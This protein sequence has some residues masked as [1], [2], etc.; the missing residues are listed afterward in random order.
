[1]GIYGVNRFYLAGSLL[2]VLWTIL[3]SVHL[4]LNHHFLLP[5][6]EQRRA[7]M[8]RYFPTKKITGYLVSCI[9]RIRGNRELLIITGLAVVMRFAAPQGI[10]SGG[11]DVIDTWVSAKRILFGLDYHLIH[12]TVRFGTIIPVYLTQL[13]FGTS[14]VVYYIAPAVFQIMTTVVLFKI[15]EMMM[16]RRFAAVICALFLVFPDTLIAGSHPRTSTFSMFFLVLAL[17][18][19]FRFLRS[20]KKIINADLVVSGVSL[21]AMYLCNEVTV[22]FFPGIALVVFLSRKSIKPLF[23]LFGVFG[24][25]F[26]CETAF[27]A[28]F[29]QYPFGRL[30]IATT[31]HLS[32][33]GNLVPVSSFMGL[34]GRF[35]PSNASYWSFLIPVFLLCSLY[36][37]I[38]RK[39]REAG[40]LAL[41]GIS[42]ILFMTIS[43]KSMH[44]VVPVVNFR[45]RYL[46]DITPVF[47]LVFCGAFS[48]FIASVMKNFSPV[49]SRRLP[50]YASVVI[51]VA[52]MIINAVV[53]TKKNYGHSDYL[54]VYPPVSVYRCYKLINDEY[55]A[56]VPVVVKGRY[57]HN[58]QA[59]R[60]ISLVREQIPG[61][62]TISEALIRANV[63]PETYQRMNRRMS[64]IFF[65]P[66][67]VFS[68]FM[69]DEKRHAGGGAVRLAEP[70]QFSLGKSHFWLYSK[71]AIPDKKELF[72]LA[73]VI[74]LDYKPFDCRKVTFKEIY[75]S[76]DFE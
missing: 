55:A 70:D 6:G 56:G 61:S 33:S 27:Y 48:V 35:T 75:E 46:S 29:T 68:A 23:V 24:L 47:I 76:G 37:L 40:Y 11:E 69:M 17:F 13:F 45:V 59:E 36:L 74:E 10:M 60:I 66:G 34:F 26:L 9:H 41:V 4:S 54:K 16:G 73:H 52:G 31:K 43:V 12:N 14:P 50:V 71:R 49:F 2:N 18:F 62:A 39:C 21:F 42:F 1:M 25:L 64:R 38:F 7:F 8:D 53:Y 28:A 57:V 58:R 3:T 19:L 44:P 65:I 15:S 67:K 63:T 32:E 5:E 20:E 30:Q 22:F 72:N 51:V